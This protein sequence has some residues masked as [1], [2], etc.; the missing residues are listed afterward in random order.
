MED[1]EVLGLVVVVGIVVMVNIHYSRPT[2]EE[3]QGLDS[4]PLVT[5]SSCVLCEA[6][7]SLSLY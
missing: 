1:C 4:F 5:L 7:L 2:L 6:A 3:E